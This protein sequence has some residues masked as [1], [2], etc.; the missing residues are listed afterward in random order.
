MQ[1]TTTHQVNNK[2][3]TNKRNNKAKEKDPNANCPALI[4][5]S[6]RNLFLVLSFLLCAWT[7][8]CTRR[9]ETGR[10]TLDCL[11]ENIFCRSAAKR[12]LAGQVKSSI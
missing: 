4:L 1:D 3:H 10:H 7:D 12:L 6:A 9:K 2:R 8:E 11:L 5:V